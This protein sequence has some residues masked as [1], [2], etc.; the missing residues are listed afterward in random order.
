M[1]VS[2]LCLLVAGHSD[3]TAGRWLVTCNLISSLHWRR[4]KASVYAPHPD[5]AVIDYYVSKHIN[6]EGKVCHGPDA[7]HLVALRHQLPP[8]LSHECREYCMNLFEENPDISTA[9]VLTSKYR[10]MPCEFRLHHVSH[11]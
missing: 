4:F 1:Q 7:E 6:A 11:A 2:P 10:Y 5:T 3:L 8:H 9:A